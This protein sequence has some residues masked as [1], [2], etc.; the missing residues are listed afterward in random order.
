MPTPRSCHQEMLRPVAMFKKGKFFEEFNLA[1]PPSPPALASPPSS[2]FSTRTSPTRRPAAPGKVWR[3]SKQ[4][5][6]A[7]PRRRLSGA[8]R[9]IDRRAS[10][11]LSLVSARS[12]TADC[13]RDRDRPAGHRLPGS[14]SSIDHRRRKVSTAAAPARHAERAGRVRGH[15][16]ELRHE[17]PR[18]CYLGRPAEP[19]GLREMRRNDPDVDAPGR[20]GTSPTPVG[21]VPSTTIWRARR[22]RWPRQPARHPPSQ[23]TRLDD[24]LGRA[25]GVSDRLPQRADDSVVAAPREAGAGPTPAPGASSRA[26]ASRAARPSGTMTTSLPAKQCIS[27]TPAP[28]PRTVVRPGRASSVRALRWGARI[29]A[30]PNSVSSAEA[31]ANRT[32]R[33]SPASEDSTTDESSHG[34]KRWASATTTTPAPGVTTPAGRRRSRSSRCL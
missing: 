9:S 27:A 26:S 28:L 15:R 4:A 20:R 25:A 33:D 23:S 6:S 5:R 14:G 21:R 13:S 1:S 2:P 29:A 12:T 10:R 18:P 17:I 34:P 8:A 7:Q 11:T 22:D 32:T 16:P 30:V 19:L 24:V 31:G 3:S